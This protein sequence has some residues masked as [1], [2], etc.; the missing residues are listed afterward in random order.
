[1]RA[2][3]GRCCFVLVLLAT[4]GAEA[5][6]DGP[7]CAARSEEPQSLCQPTGGRLSLSDSREQCWPDSVATVGSDE[8]SGPRD[9]M[10]TARKNM[11][12]ADLLYKSGKLEDALLHL[13][14][15]EQ[16]PTR[17]A[18]RI[19]LRRGEL[20]RELN[21]PEQ[22]CEAYALATQS[23]DREVAVRA[24]IG[25]VYCALEA[26]DKKAEAQLQALLSRY[27]HLTA[28]E[29]L[30]FT[31]ALARERWGNPQGAAALLRKIDLERPATPVA[32]RARAELAR[33][34]EQG[35]KV[36][37]YN[38]REQVLRA[39]RLLHSGPVEDAADAVDAMREEAK[40]NPSL[41]VQVEQLDSRI[42]RVQGRFDQIKPKPGSAGASLVTTAVI[43]APGEPTLGERRIAA[44]RG[45]RSAAKLSSGQV[46]QLLELAIEYGDAGLA[47]EM[48]GEV[49]T[50]RVFGP[51][52]RFM[53]GLR[54]SGLAEDGAVAGLFESLL[55]TRGYQLAA[56]YYRARAL[57]RQSR[58]A[59]AEAE[60]QNVV[61]ADQ[62]EGYYAMWANGRLEALREQ[63]GGSCLPPREEPGR[64]PHAP[65]PPIS[66]ACHAPVAAVS[67]PTPLSAVSGQ[68][69]EVLSG[70]DAALL[71]SAESSAREELAVTRE[72]IAASYETEPLQ[73][74]E[75][76]SE[77]FSFDDGAVA[78]VLADSEAEGV[79][80]NVAAPSSTASVISPPVL[81][82]SVAAPA[83]RP[84]P[85]VIEIREPAARRIRALELLVPLAT[86]HG[87]AF[88]WLLRAQDL[89]EL[90]RFDEAADELSEAYIAWRDAKGGAP[91]RSGLLSLLTGQPP[92]RRPASPQLRKARLA[93]DE[94]ARLRMSE[95]ATLLGDAGIGF[96]LGGNG[97]F[98]PR[99]YAD[100]V[101]QAAA[102]FGIDPNLLFA[103]MRVESVFNR[104]ILSGAGAVG[105]M[106]IMPHTGQRIAYRLKIDDFEP[107]Q[108]LT[109]Q[110]SLEFS[111]WY[112]ASLVR[113]FDGRLPLAIAAYNG[114]PHN[115]RLWLRNNRPDMPLDAFLERIPFKETNHY[116][117][118]VLSFYA[119][120]RAQVHLPAAPLLVALP[121]L[122]PDP[123]AF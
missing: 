103:V 123:M 77:P 117:R 83:P 85:T 26:S 52:L 91:I 24:Q 89:V 114:G 88:P 55:Q 23:P 28:R 36:E 29:S 12:T 120:Y 10:S 104:R 60:F 109:P 73:S 47:T 81:E 65:A 99:A 32:G 70:P 46:R 90:E 37:P 51:D 4:G 113:R 74:R 95:L 97:K 82:P 66:L 100:S 107:T 9:F 101:E 48:V 30:S 84:M 119:S 14:S 6:S 2:V 18:D 94:D 39:E 45:N 111:A 58:L 86:Q 20:L 3:V 71:S 87:E 110:R 93:L 96:R 8:G 41:R 50:R 72:E 31:L 98:Q 68:T 5:W 54:A 92:P 76:D 11:Q 7:L 42:A 121:R 34:R 16:E 80:S 19:A 79:R 40:T 116:V 69:P 105:L 63:V 59:E 43:A 15:V 56:H 44:V 67:A 102:K 106:Q 118:R 53:L 115:V 62:S 22:A 108:L 61:T 27:P 38:W 49:T 25:S 78:A 75:E 112:L 1:M 21:M 122:E 57:E 13:R 35:V 17:V 64:G 33:L